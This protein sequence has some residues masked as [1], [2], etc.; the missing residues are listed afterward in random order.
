MSK[1]E[2]L[3]LRALYEIERRLENRNFA[4]DHAFE[5]WLNH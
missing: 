4:K 2:R 3:A 1:T 5:E